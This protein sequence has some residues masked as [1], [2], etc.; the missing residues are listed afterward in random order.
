M[1]QMVECDITTHELYKAKEGF[2]VFFQGGHDNPHGK[3][4]LLEFWVDD[5]EKTREFVRLLTITI[6]RVVMEGFSYC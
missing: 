1:E 2:C 4:I 6:N 3:W 5:I